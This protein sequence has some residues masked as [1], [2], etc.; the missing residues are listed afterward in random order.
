MMGHGVAASAVGIEIAHTVTWIETVRV[1]DYPLTSRST[2]RGRWEA[3]TEILDRGHVRETV[4]RSSVSRGKR[5]EEMR[6][7]RIAALTMAATLLVVGLTV[8]FGTARARSKRSLNFKSIDVALPGVTLTAAFG[9]NAQGDI[10]G[11]YAVGS[12]GHGYLLSDGTYTTI[13][14]P[15]GVGRTQAQGINEEGQIVGQYTVPVRTDVD[16][17][18]VFTRSFLRDPDG[19]FSS[20]QFPGANN[21]LA[22]KISPG[23]KVVGCFH[24]LSGD[25]P[26]TMHGFVL[27]DGNYEEFPVPGSMHNGITRNGLTIVGVVFLDFTTFHAYMVHHGVSQMIDPP[28]AVVSDA[29]DVNPSGEIVGFFVDSANKT[30][31]FLLREGDFTTIDFPGEDVVSTQ[32]RGINPQGDIVGFYVSKDASGVSHTHGFVATRNKDEDEDK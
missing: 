30:H 21:T 11:R 9:I 28:D 5:G 3:K 26:T 20:I 17:A 10:V 16:P 22:I 8:P 24:N 25:F 2:L 29:R 23:G 6:K 14:A 18:G 15:D 13:D 31:G 27:Q 4:S 1:D 19:T 7:L 32:A 12:V